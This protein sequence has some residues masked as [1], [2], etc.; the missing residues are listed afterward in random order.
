M[1][2]RYGGALCALSAVFCVVTAPVSASPL[3]TG[4]WL[5]IARMSNSDFGMFDGNG[6]FNPAYTFGSFSSS[7]QVDDFHRPFSTYAGMSILFITGDQQIWGQTNYAELKGL[8]DAQSNNFNPNITFNAHFGGTD[9]TVMGNVLSRAGAPED[10]W[11][12]LLGGHDQG[13]ATGMILWGESDYP[14]SQHA[15]LKNLHSGVNVYVSQLIAA[16]PLPGALPLFA[17]VL[18]L[19]GIARWRRKFAML[20]GRILGR[21]PAAAAG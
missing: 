2:T 15:L 21:A 20:R 12:S 7:L 13:V 1:L 19:L 16:V 8:I 5:Q 17:S 11:I 4:S 14:S 18:G 3:D 10:P 6:A 9:Q